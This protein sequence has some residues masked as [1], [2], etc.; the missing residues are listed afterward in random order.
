MGNRKRTSSMGFLIQ[1][2]LRVRKASRLNRER[3]ALSIPALP[4]SSAAL[5]KPLPLRERRPRVLCDFVSG[6]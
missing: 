6:L 4:L 5:V 3:L 2:E 1:Y